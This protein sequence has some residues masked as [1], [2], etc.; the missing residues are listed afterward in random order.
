MFILLLL[1]WETSALYCRTDENS[2]ASMQVRKGNCRSKNN[3]KNHINN[4]ST[5]T[6]FNTND[7]YKI[8]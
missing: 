7:Y 4:K 6:H 2:K 5:V 8:P 3:N 1:E